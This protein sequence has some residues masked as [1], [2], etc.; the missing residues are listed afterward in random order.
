MKDYHNKI[1]LTILK[2]ILKN[3]RNTPTLSTKMCFLF[4]RSSPQLFENRYLH[5]LDYA[6]AMGDQLG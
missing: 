3:F 6:L 1:C 5:M 2:K 4:E